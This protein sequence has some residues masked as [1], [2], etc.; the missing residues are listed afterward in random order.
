MHAKQPSDIA[1]LDVFEDVVAFLAPRT[2]PVL[3]RPGRTI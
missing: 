3:L 1:M 2:T